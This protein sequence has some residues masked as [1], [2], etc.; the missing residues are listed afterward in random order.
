MARIHLLLLLKRTLL[1]IS[2]KR[3][4]WT[5][6]ETRAPENC[7]AFNELPVGLIYEVQNWALFV[8][9]QVHQPRESFYGARETRHHRENFIVERLTK[10]YDNSSL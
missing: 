4:Q 8:F 7:R 3:Y 2:E 1:P 10:M 5:K 6:T 9:V